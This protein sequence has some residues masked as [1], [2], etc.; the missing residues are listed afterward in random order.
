MFLFSINTLVHRLML[1]TK[2]DLSD[3]IN[4][5]FKRGIWFIRNTNRNVIRF[6]YMSILIRFHLRLSKEFP[7]AAIH[8]N[9]D[10]MIWFHE[11]QQLYQVEC[12]QIYILCTKKR[13]KS[14]MLKTLFACMLLPQV[15]S[16][17]TCELTCVIFLRSSIQCSPLF[18][19]LSFSL[20]IFF[21]FQHSALPTHVRFDMFRIGLWS[22]W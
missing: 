21:L 16:L 4:L 15:Y 9:V 1:M 3:M 19:S 13:R 11:V 20:N 7:D 8:I 5:F 18:L 17:L 6:S 14:Y 22:I 2:I 12:V 10:K